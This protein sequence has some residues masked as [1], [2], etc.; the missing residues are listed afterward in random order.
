MSLVQEQPKRCFCSPTKNNQPQDPKPGLFKGCNNSCS[1]CWDNHHPICGPFYSC[2][3]FDACCMACDK[4]GIGS[5]DFQGGNCEKDCPLICLPCYIVVDTLC[6]IP[7]IFGCW[8]AT[9]D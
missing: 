7:I 5:K 3:A 1:K 4:P 8:K 6:F 9:W 2:L